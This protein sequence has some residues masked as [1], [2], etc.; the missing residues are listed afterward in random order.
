MPKTL[1]ISKDVSA[2]ASLKGNCGS[3]I[4]SMRALMKWELAY[5]DTTESKIYD[6]CN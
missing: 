4:I 5:T 2:L 1:L 6:G 3:A